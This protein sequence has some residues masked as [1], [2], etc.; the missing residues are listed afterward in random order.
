MLS[1]MKTPLPLRGN[2]ATTPAMAF[3]L[4]LTL[5]LSGCGGG[6]GDEPAAG[7]SAASPPSGEVPAPTA[8]ADAAAP[9]PAG[10]AGTRATCGLADFEAE[11]LRLINAYRAAGASCGSRGSFAATTPLAWNAAL[12]QASL[13]HADDML[14]GNF[15]SHTG[16][17]GSSAGDRATAAG[18]AWSAWGENIAAGQ[19]T[20]AVVVAGWMAS[21]GHCANLMQPAFRDIGMVCLNAAAGSKYRT[22]WAQLLGASR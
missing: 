11:A 18:Y 14:A 21:P 8:P 5:L 19:P 20:V 10:V 4:A 13:V 12:T 22:Y 1:R 15:F 6:G 2:I 16:S 3:A 7:S 17:D 9:P